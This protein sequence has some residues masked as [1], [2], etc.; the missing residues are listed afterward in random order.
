MFKY[1]VSLYITELMFL[2]KLVKLTKLCKFVKWKC[3]VKCKKA[4][5]NYIFELLVHLT[6]YAPAV[7]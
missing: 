3:P 4:D 2:G 5:F 7:H 6:L 1:N